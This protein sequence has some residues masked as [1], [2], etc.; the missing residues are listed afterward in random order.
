MKLS[1]QVGAALAII[2]IL[3]VTGAAITHQHFDTGNLS[4]SDSSTSSNVVSSRTLFTS[5]TAAYSTGS[6]AQWTT[7]HMNNSRS[8]FDPNEAQLGS[9]RSAWNS[10]SLD[11]TVYPEPL[12][13]N[14]VLYVATENDS[15][16]ALNETTG[17]V[18]WRTNVGAPIPGSSLPCGDI[19]PSGITGRQS[20]TLTQARFM[21]WPT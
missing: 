10:S 5:E 7:Y 2:V 3:V 14:R 9:V 17:I 16:Y 8:G 21:L 20:L 6:S 11:G 18:I 13:A 19:D 4:N 12:L 1:S 15:I